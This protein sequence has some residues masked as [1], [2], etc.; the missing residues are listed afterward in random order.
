MT[1]R[2]DKEKMAVDDIVVAGAVALLMQVILGSVKDL[3]DVAPG[4]VN[5]GDGFDRHRLAGKDDL[6]T[7]GLGPGG[8]DIGLALQHPGGS[9]ELG[10]EQFL[11]GRSAALQP[12]FRRLRGLEGL[13]LCFDFKLENRLHQRRGALGLHCGVAH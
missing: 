9:G 3:L 4:A 5:L 8:E 2:N 11:V 12:G 13:V 6:L 1:A 10:L 7:E